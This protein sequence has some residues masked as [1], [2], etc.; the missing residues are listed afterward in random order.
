[1]HKVKRDRIIIMRKYLFI[2]GL[3]TMALIVG[4]IYGI[5]MHKHSDQEW[6]IFHVL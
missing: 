4:P 3:L 2:C 1:M 6:K 5:L